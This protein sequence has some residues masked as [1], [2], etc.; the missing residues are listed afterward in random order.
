M[1]VYGVYIFLNTFFL[2]AYVSPHQFKEYTSEE[3]STTN[4]SPNKYVTVIQRTE[5]NI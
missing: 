3:E 4:I 1:Y 2:R 5:K